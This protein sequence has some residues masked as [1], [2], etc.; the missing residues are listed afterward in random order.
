MPDAIVFGPSGSPVA[1]MLHAE[2]L[3]PVSVR[4]PGAAFLAT[5]GALKSIRKGTTRR[6]KTRERKP[7]S[8]EPGTGAFPGFQAPRFPEA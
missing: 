3:H 7:R 8:H 6:F 4:N 2:S 5:V 1:P